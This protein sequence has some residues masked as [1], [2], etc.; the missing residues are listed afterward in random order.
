M[1]WATHSVTTELV[2]AENWALPA[3][4]H[5]YWVS[6]SGCT[7]TA[8][9]PLLLV[10]VCARVVHDVAAHGRDHRVTAAFGM[11]APV[12]ELRKVKVKV[13]ECAAL[14]VALREVEI[15]VPAGAAAPAVL[16]A[17]LAAKAAA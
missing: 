10:A 3:K 13:V 2:C 14:T 9:T 12:V 15:A 1:A 16:T 5:T 17:V 11:S 4:V 7:T 6:C 8:A